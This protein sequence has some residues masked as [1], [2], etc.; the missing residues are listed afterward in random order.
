MK[1]NKVFLILS[2][3]VV[4]TVA[5]NLKAQEKKDV[6]YWY[7]S[8]YKIP[9]SK[10]DSLNKFV[11]K[12]TIPVVEE[13][14]KQ[15]YILDYNLLIHHTGDEYNVVI[16]NK[17]SSWEE[18]GKGNRFNKVMEKLY[19][20]NAKRDSINSKIRWIFENPVHI[21]NIYR[22]AMHIPK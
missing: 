16:M 18:M 12:Y 5:P 1:S 4:F 15:G 3:V 9:W 6:H 11:K 7:V 13:A 10:I 21:D 14:K 17:Y 8:S 20:D 22:D 19:P 2:L